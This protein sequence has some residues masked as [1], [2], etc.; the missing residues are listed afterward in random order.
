MDAGNLLD[1]VSDHLSVRRAFGAAYEKDGTP[2]GPPRGLLDLGAGFIA[3]GVRGTIRRCRGLR[4][5]G[6]PAPSAGL[7]WRAVR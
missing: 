6:L 4:G 1:K 2:Q 5:S 7:A 3:V